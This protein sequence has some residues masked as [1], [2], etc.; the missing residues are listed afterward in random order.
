MKAVHSVHKLDLVFKGHVPYPA[1]FFPK[2]TK[3]CLK[4]FSQRL[5]STEI[6][7]WSCHMVI[8]LSSLA[9]SNHKVFLIFL[10]NHVWN[11]NWATMYIMLCSYFFKLIFPVIT[12]DAPLLALPFSFIFSWLSSFYPLTQ[13]S[14]ARSLP[15]FIPHYYFDVAFCSF[16]RSSYITPSIF[17]RMHC[18]FSFLSFPYF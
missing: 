9:L 10:V 18:N 1:T 17:L 8:Y 3:S 5:R 14:P 12:S 4:A 7:I 11:N 2:S 13:I 6:S 15:R 16:Q